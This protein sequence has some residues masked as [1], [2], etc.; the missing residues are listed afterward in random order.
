[1]NTFTCPEC[2]DTEM[3]WDSST[4]VEGS[5]EYLDYEE[6]WFCPKCG[7]EAKAEAHYI[8]DYR[9]FDFSDQRKVKKVFRNPLCK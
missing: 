7:K 6:V 1:M 8:I 9:D 5:N 4:F 2:G 3:I